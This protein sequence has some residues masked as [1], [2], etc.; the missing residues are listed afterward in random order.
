M[1]DL[2]SVHAKLDAIAGEHLSDEPGGLGTG[3][4]AVAECL[5]V[6]PEELLADA[7]ER[8]KGA[9]M[10]GSA[11]HLEPHEL[12]GLLLATFVDAFL[13]GA[14]WGREPGA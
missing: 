4:H 14:A 8:I 10:L 5:G 9:V 3:A 2:A 13:T 11:A 12:A 6:D 7:R 1:I